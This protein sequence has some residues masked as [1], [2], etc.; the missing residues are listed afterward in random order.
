MKAH[1][2]YRIIVPAENLVQVVQTICKRKDV[3]MTERWV[4]DFLYNHPN[5]PSL[6]ALNDCFR[7]LG[8]TAKSLR[9][10]QKEN[11]KKLNDVHIVQIKD[12]DNNEQFAVI[13]RYE[14]DFVLWHNPKSLRDERIS[15]DEF[16]KIFMGYVM[17]LSEASEKHEPHYRRHL[18]E[19]TF[20]NVLFLIA[21]LAAP[22]SALFRAWNEP[23]NL[24]FVLLAIVGYVLGLLLVLHE[25]SQY[26]PLTQRVCGG[27]HEKLNCDAVLSSSASRFLAIPWAVWGGTYFLALILII[28]IGNIDVSTLYW[29]HLLTLPYVLFSIYYQR[30]VVKQWCP[31]CLGVVASICLIPIVGLPFEQYEATISFKH[32]PQLLIYAVVAFV[33][34][35]QLWQWGENWRSRR[36]LG[37]EFRRLH[38]DASV[39][40]TKLQK[41]R[42]LTHDCM[43]LGVYLGNPQGEIQ[44]IEIC[45]PFCYPCAIAQKHLHQLLEDR[46]DVG[47][48]ILFLYPEEWI[49]KTPIPTFLAL[50]NKEKLEEA[51]TDWF[52]STDK[53]LSKFQEKYTVQ[54]SL[55]EATKQLKAMNEFCTA[56]QINAT[57]TI[58]V[59][60]HEMPANYNVAD[61]QYCL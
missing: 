3:L 42:I 34:L 28:G 51:I 58:Y 47:L 46:E 29:L 4:S 6:S 38:L 60:G 15:W 50:K 2:L 26:S 39:F 1:L 10:S 55:V 40:A 30:F 16:E 9:L 36:W 33:L 19:N 41:E 21:T 27:Q 44:L 23:A 43:D 61:L 22:V 14:G 52:A 57:P 37:K 59:N 11:A 45:N 13:Y 12:E 56:E 7:R 31:L 17:L 18:I 32:L 48:R 35:Y 5:Y 8:I 54:L 53:S 20:H 25:V 49:A 24:S